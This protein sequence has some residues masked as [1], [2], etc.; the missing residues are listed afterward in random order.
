MLIRHALS[1]EQYEVYQGVLGHYHVQT[2]KQDPGPAFQW[3]AV[4]FG[5]RILM[6]PEALA[7]N[8][9]ARGKPARFIASIPSQKNGK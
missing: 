3:D 5:A 8:A 9:A 2:D 4:I 7:A 6:T 1:G